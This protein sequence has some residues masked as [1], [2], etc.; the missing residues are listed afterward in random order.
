MKDKNVITI[1]E[2]IVISQE[3]HDLVLETGDRVRVLPASEKKEED[4]DLIDMMTDDPLPED[5]FIDEPIVMDDPYF[6]DEPDYIEVPDDYVDEPIVVD[7]PEVVDDLYDGFEDFE[8]EEE[9]L[10]DFDDVVNAENAV[11]V[12]VELDHDFYG[13]EET[14]LTIENEVKIS[15]DG[16]D[17]ILESGDKIR[18]LKEN[19]F[20]EDHPINIKDA[21]QMIKDEGVEEIDI[22]YGGGLI[23]DHNSIF[24]DRRFSV[25]DE[26]GAIRLYSKDYTILIDTVGAGLFN[27][28]TS[29][30][31]RKLNTKEIVI[32]KNNEVVH[33]TLLSIR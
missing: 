13:N 20:H 14:V 21:I 8:D 22:L 23:K 26:G 28:E 10:G 5:E 32:K 6:N 24:K 16:H 4:V 30:G 15:Q 9:V 7:E 11:N 25:R 1:Q 19:F 27:R 29:F 2:E 31:G 18:V 17:V 3:G 12:G 33:L